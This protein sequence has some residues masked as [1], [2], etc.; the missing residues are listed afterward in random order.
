MMSPLQFFLGFLIGFLAVLLSALAVA[1]VRT[2]CMKRTSAASATPPPSDNARAAQYGAVLQTMIRH[3]TIS[4]RFD[5]SREK[6]L[7]FQKELEPL[8]P[9]IFAQCEIAHPGAGLVIRCAGTGASAREPIL[10]MSHHDVVAAP[11]EGWQHAPFSGDIDENGCLWGRGTVDTK[12]SLFCELQALEELLASGWQPD[13]DVYIT[14]SCTEEWSGESAPEIVRYLKERGVHLGMLLDEGGMIVEEPLAGAHGKYGVVGVL[15]KGYGDVRF[16]AMGHG[17]H[18]SAPTKNTPLVRLAKFMTHVERAQPFRAELTPTVKEMFRRL[19]PNMGFGMRLVFG[20][21]WLF[22]GLL[23]KLMPA[24]SPMG[25]AMIQTTCAF[26][27]AK[28]SDGLNVLPTEA[29]ITA[30]LRFIHHQP[31]AESLAILDRI[32]AKYDIQSEVIFEAPPCKPVAY[33]SEAFAFLE[34]TAAAIYPGYGMMP[35]V[36]T[37]GTDAKFYEEICE[38]ALRFAPIEIT[39]QQLASVHAR[40]ENLTLRALPPAVDFYKHLL[41]S[42]ANS[43]T[44]TP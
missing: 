6:F 11:P 10:L 1:I 18:A 13:T 8:F 38:N 16:T 36:M 27:T 7:A 44:V 15:E 31:N 42:Y 25:A 39:P 21:L 23:T 37:G 3:E 32:A 33:D 4:S 5:P 29:S 30:N 9:H 12:G 24:I 14:S 28:G 26:T 17:G 40:D 41:C 19:A 43:G 35:Y 22:G 34:Q 20:N 2:L